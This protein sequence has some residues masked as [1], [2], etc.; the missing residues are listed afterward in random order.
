MAFNWRQLLGLDGPGTAS[1][2]LGPD[3]PA[4]SGDRERGKFRPSKYPRL[5]TIAITG[6]DGLPASHYTTELLE[7]I[8]SELRTMR[9]GMTLTGIVAEID[10]PTS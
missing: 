10:E 7:N 6:D 8:L 2:D 5:T 4:S 3:F 1:T 9:Q